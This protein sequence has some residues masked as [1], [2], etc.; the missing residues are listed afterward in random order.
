MS[1]D[2]KGR[3]CR[4][5]KVWLFVRMCECECVDRTHEECGRQMAARFYG[6][7]KLTTPNNTCILRVIWRRAFWGYSGTILPIALRQPGVPAITS[8]PARD[9]TT[10][11]AERSA[12]VYLIFLIL[13]GCIFITT[14]LNIMHHDLP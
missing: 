9:G 2:R 4:E 10:G 8:R 14:D 3:C 5:A 12:D 11:V 1:L 13:S 6:T 7:R